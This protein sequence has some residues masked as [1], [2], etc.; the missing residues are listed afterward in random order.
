MAIIPAK[1]NFTVDR[2]ADFGLRLTFKDSTGSAIDLT[3]Y[4]VAVSCWSVNSETGKRQ[5]KYADFAI[6]YTNRTNGIIDISLTDT[7][8]A[9]FGIDELQ[10]DVLLTEPSGSKNYYLEGKLFISEGLTE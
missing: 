2:R 4:S 6:Q 5:F 3:G 10:Y 7:Q 9:T 1:K 8:T